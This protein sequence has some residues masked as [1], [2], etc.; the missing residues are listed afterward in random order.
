MEAANNALKLISRAIEQL[1]RIYCEDN[2]ELKLRIERCNQ[3]LI[4]AIDKLS[5]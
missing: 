5:Q 1:D 4:E 3:F 2:E